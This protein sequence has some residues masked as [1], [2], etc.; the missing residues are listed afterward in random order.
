MKI[1]SA[2]LLLILA[3]CQSEPD[4]KPTASFTYQKKENGIVEFKSVISGEQAID[5][6]FGDGKGE[7]K[8]KNPLH[9]YTRNGSYDVKLT[10][11]G[12]H[13]NTE[14]VS[15]VVVDNIEGSVV[16]WMQSMRNKEIEVSIAGKTAKIT[17]FYS[18][19]NSPACGANYC[20][21]F[22]RLKPGAYPF[23]ARELNS[24]TP[25]I[26]NGTVMIDQKGCVSRKLAY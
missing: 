20:A 9:E 10:A 5:W 4:P 8:D 21:T 18:S 17:G 3:A 22:D 2:F 24:I 1:Y 16:F 13:G 7:M 6:N 11:F 26:W 14:F 19:G 12:S 25:T 15:T 23:E